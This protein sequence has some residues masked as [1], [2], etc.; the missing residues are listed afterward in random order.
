MIVKWLLNRTSW[1]NRKHQNSS[2]FGYALH[3]ELTLDESGS[4]AAIETG[5]GMLMGAFGARGTLLAAA[6]GGGFELAAAADGLVLRMRSDEVDG[7]VATTAEVERL[8]LTL[9]GSYRNLPLLGG[10]LTPAL[11]VGG[12]YDGGDAETGAGLLVGG[13]LRYAV[14]A[15]GLTVAGSGQGLLLHETGGFAEWG[16]GGSLQFSPWPDGRGPSLRVARSWGAT[17]TSARGLWALPD[18]SRLP[19]G[20][21]FDPGGGQLDAEFS[22]GLAALAGAATV[23]PYAGLTM[24]DGTRAWSLGARLRHDPSLS[25]TVAGTRREHTGAEPEHTLELRASLRH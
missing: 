12:R 1:N 21:H 6:P 4:A 18:A 15:W 7:L 17:A 11:E 2:L 25:L 24:A 14:P 20:D 13:S 3:G 23:T 9:T 8:R 19:A 22:Y 16:A 10:V 5:A